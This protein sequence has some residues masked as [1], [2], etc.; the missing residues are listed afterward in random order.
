VF[1]QPL[2][3]EDA[4]GSSASASPGRKGRGAGDSPGGVHGWSYYGTGRGS[5][6]STF[7]PYK[8]DLVGF[9]ANAGALRRSYHPF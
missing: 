9:F 7:L 4:A 2:P 6:R 5:R 1:L 3:Q 8:Q